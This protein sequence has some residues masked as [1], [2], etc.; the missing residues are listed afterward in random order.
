MSSSRQGVTIVDLLIL[1]SIA[2]ISLAILLPVIQRNR[3][4]ARRELC[5]DNL[6]TLG[7]ASME[8]DDVNGQYPPYVGLCENV[9]DLSD[10]VFLATDLP[11]TFS[12]VQLLPYIDQ[13][14]LADQLDPVAFELTCT[15][16][17]SVGY[18]AFGSWLLG[19]DADM[20]GV[21]TMFVDN[22][23]ELYRCPTDTGYMPLE[24]TMGVM[25]STNNASVGTFVF[26]PSGTQRVSRTITNYTSNIG[27]LAVTDTPSNPDFEGLYGP[28]RSRV[29]DSMDS[30]PDGA[31][32]T[33]LFGENIGSID[34]L[35]TTLRNARFSSVL[36]GF[37]VGRPDRY[38]VSDFAFGS[39]D[40]S[41]WLQFGS[42][43]PKVVNML[44]ADGSVTG[45]SRNVDLDA[46]GRMCSVA[47][48]EPLFELQSK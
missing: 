39:A 33:I 45:F 34:P 19:L 46:F 47:D 13:Q 3:E 2:S 18:F 48:G 21:A 9:D 16:L 31:S 37:S 10:F 4:A 24:S 5:I 23:V 44:R 11:F 29:S 30:I 27:A 6:Q 36:A 28:I 20:P 17:S 14:Q 8:Y 42:A 26:P 41:H 35:G 32:T 12:Q 38:G 22:Q 40:Q 25:S 7:I 15:Q 1:L 43:H